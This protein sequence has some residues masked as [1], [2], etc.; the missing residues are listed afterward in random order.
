MT[1]L[2][3]DAILNINDTALVQVDVPEWGGAVYVRPM[4]G[5]DRDAYDLEMVQAGGKIENM[6][7]RIAVRVVCDADGN[8][9][10][11]PE[12]ADALGKKS[13]KALDRIYAAME[14]TSKTTA[15]GI[16]QLK[17]D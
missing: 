12:D 2:S 10:F 14:S 13:A 16:A 8:L 9:M 15:D 3:R 17:K 7:A 11:K 5:R 4:S 6:R 1:T